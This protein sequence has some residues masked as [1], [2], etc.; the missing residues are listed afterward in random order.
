[1]CLKIQVIIA[2]FAIT[3]FAHGEIKLYVAPDGNDQWTGRLPGANSRATDGP[4]AT[5]ERARDEIRRLKTDRGVQPADAVTV[6]VRAGTYCLLKTFQLEPGDSGTPASPV[7]YRG[8]A[9]ERPTLTGGGV[10]TNFH[11]YRGSI[12]K[13]DVAAQGFKNIHF[14]Q[15]FLDGKRQQLA[16]YPNYAPDN[17]IAG[18][19]AYVDGTVTSIYKENPAASK[20]I[21]RCKAGDVHEWSRPQ[22]GE[23]MIFPRFNWSNNL[24]RI[25]AVSREERTITLSADAHHQIY[26]GDRYYVRNLFEELDAEGEWYL[27]KETSTLYFWPPA[28]RAE[29]LTVLAPRLDSMLRFAPGTSNIFVQGFALEC[30]EGSAIVLQDARDCVLAGNIIRNT[31]GRCDNS[32]AIAISGGGNNRAVGNDISEIGAHGITLDGGETATLLAAGNC[33]ENNYIHHVGVY[34]GHGCGI[35]VGGVGQRVVH[36]LIHDTSRCGIFGTG[37]DHVI[38]YN[39]IRHANLV[40]EDTGGI[41]LCGPRTGW[42][43][44]GIVVRHNFIHD[45]LGFG[46]QNGK[47]TSPYYSWGI[48]L[49]DGI[50]WVQVTD[51]IIVRAPTGGIFIHGG[52]NNVVENNVIV[53]GGEGQMTFMAWAPPASLRTQMEQWFKACHY[54]PAYKKFAELAALDPSVIGQMTENQ[55]V[56]NIVCYSNPESKLYALTRLDFAT[57]KA[58]WN[59]FWHFGLPLLMD[60]PDVPP[61]EQW[62]AW[63]KMG[64]D[65]NSLVA[66]PLFM[67]TR[68]DDFGP[69]SASPAFKLGFKPVVREQIG[70]YKDPLRATWPIREAAGVR[71]KAQL[72]E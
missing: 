29:E 10:I 30:C 56:H 72:S 41:Y 15:L 23:V 17:P 34:N 4:F 6:L 18:G 16:R 12:L 14:R 42:S 40:T 65:V 3:W 33:A 59:L 53:D 45:I 71:E 66:D 70:P 63:R 1:M 61:R 43:P 28:S 35:V 26:A 60:L 57:T 27:D 38:E 46:R 25:A 54:N 8:Y 13:T 49:D 44:S 5:L 55:F 67:D 64:F 9:D 7:V 11:A 2:F 62:Q 32:A 22:D 24:L 19:W 51:N 47:W 20:R 48:Y 21:I 58:D 52:R 68:K 37:H 39:H 31:G 69:R 50:S 36:N